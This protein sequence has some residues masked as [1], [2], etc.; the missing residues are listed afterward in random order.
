MVEEL[1]RWKSALTQRL[2]NYQETSKQ[3]LEDFNRIN[4]QNLQVYKNLNSVSEK[5]S[6][7]QKTKQDN[8]NNLFLAKANMELSEKISNSLNLPTQHNLIED[9]ICHTNAEKNLVKV[10]T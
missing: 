9:K 3:L 5:T 4:R 6:N 10:F 2:Y 7:E 1:A 8:T